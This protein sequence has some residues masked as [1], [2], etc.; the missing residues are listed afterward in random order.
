MLLLQK[1]R[2]TIKE[3]KTAYELA[4]DVENIIDGIPARVVSF[5]K[6][7]AFG[8]CVHGAKMTLGNGWRIIAE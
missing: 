8:F 3:Y 6:K 5:I 7:N 1:N 4:D 2:K